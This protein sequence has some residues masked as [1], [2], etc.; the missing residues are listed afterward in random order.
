MNYYNVIPELNYWMKI[1]LN[2]SPLNNVHRYKPIDISSN[3]I[4]PTSVINLLF[5]E[6]FNSFQHQ[7]SSSSSSSDSLYLYEYIQSSISSSTDKSLYLR[8]KLY[9]GRLNVFC[10]NSD[11][12][13]NQINSSCEP[14]NIFGLEDDDFTLLDKLWLYRITTEEVDL[15]DIDYDELTTILSKLIFIYLDAFINNSFDHYNT[16]ETIS[17]GSS[18]LEMAYEK[19]VM[20]MLYLV[21]QKSYGISWKDT[22]IIND[23]L[24]EINEDI[25]I[26]L[27]PK[28]QSY[29]IDQT[30][31]DDGYITISENV[32]WDRRDFTMF[33]NGQ[34]VDQDIKY[35]ITIDSSDVTDVQTKILFLDSSFELDEIIKC[36]WSYADPSSPFTS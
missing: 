2:D 20:D 24:V 23:E 33:K 15:D 35:T 26:N 34:I 17:D 7:S 22:Q 36:I 31:I 14:L 10:C 5:N 12:F 28:V 29:T 1:F 18:L 32:P 19:Y 4:E 25:F 11:K 27:T 21:K 16:D 30:M 3:W 9:V 6:T 13:A 8:S